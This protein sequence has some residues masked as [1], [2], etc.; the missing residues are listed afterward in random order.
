M[1]RHMAGSHDKHG[2]SRQSRQN[3]HRDSSHHGLHHKLEYKKCC[4]FSAMISYIVSA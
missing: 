2:N 4:N 3:P 1:T